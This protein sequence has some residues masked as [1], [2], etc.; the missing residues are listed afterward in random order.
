MEGREGARNSQEFIHNYRPGPF[1][2]EVVYMQSNVF[3]T[4]SYTH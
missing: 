3:V 4:L 2:F 1:P